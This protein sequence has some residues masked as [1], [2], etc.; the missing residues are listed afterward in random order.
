MPTER[1]VLSTLADAADAV[2]REGVRP[3]AV[4][5]VGQVVALAH[6]SAY[7]RAASV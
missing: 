2:D 6:P 4:V 3:P 1:T 7:G 5:V